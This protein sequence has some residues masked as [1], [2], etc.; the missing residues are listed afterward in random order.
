MKIDEGIL[1]DRNLVC[2]VEL[3]EATRKHHE[4]EK[5]DLAANLRA[6]IGCIRKAAKRGWA[7]VDEWTWILNGMLDDYAETLAAAGIVVKIT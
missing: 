6:V 3:P 4:G 2:M 1:A 5:F 7:S